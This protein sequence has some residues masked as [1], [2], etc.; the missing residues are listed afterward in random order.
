M[1]LRKNSKGLLTPLEKRIAKA[2]L[3]E[4]WRN[5]DIQAL[6]NIGREATI[7]SARITNVKQNKRQVVATI[8][9]VETFKIRKQSYDARTGLNIVDD[10]RLI[11]SREAMILA[12]QIFNSAGLNFKTE[13]FAVLAN[14][15]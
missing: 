5:Q 10:E 14:I 11:R 6:F 15:A 8:E 9:E 13:V 4:K 12:V 1:P 7:N 3:A 2:L